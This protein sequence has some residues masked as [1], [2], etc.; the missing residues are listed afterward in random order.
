MSQIQVNEEG[1]GM[2]MALQFKEVLFWKGIGAGVP[3][4]AC[5]VV[6]PLLLANS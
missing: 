5:R 1:K 4:V 2:E 3:Q 6:L